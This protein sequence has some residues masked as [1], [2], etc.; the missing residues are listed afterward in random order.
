MGERARAATGQHEAD[1][2]S[3]QAAGGRVDRA[4]QRLLA[5]AEVDLSRR[6]RPKRLV[7]QLASDDQQLA[8]V[9]RRVS[10]QPGR[11]GGALGHREDEIGLA[12]AEV[13]PGRPLVG[14]ARA[15]EQDPLVRVLGRVEDGEVVGRGAP[16]IGPEL[17]EG[18]VAGECAGESRGD[19]GGRDAGVESDHGDCRRRHLTGRR[20][21]VDGDLLAHRASQRERELG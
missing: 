9:Q 14:V 19:G 1:G 7:G 5:V 4:L 2:P 21:A 18:A 15:D 11:V 12:Q 20:P 10:A 17:A 16:A 3:A 13:R 6:D 8:A